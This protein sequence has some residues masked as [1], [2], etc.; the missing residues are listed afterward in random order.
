MNLRLILPVVLAV[1]FLTAGGMYALN[2]DDSAADSG[3]G[4][5]NDILDDPRVIAATYRDGS[6]S[7]VELPI[8]YTAV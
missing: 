1:A 5:L 4:S 3:N 6:F 8:G 7:Y 2:A